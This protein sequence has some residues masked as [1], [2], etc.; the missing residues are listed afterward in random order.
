MVVVVDMVE[1]RKQEEV[2]LKHIVIFTFCNFVSKNVFIDTTVRN[3]K[4]QLSYVTAK[5]HV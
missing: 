4:G 1:E 2:A 5:T 3:L